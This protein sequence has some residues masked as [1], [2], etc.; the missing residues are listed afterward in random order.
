MGGTQENLYKGYMSDGISM[1][2][3]GTLFINLNAVV[4]TIQ[5]GLL[6]LSITDVGRE[7]WEHCYPLSKIICPTQAEKQK[8][9]AEQERGR[10]YLSH[11]ETNNNNNKKSSMWPHSIQLDTNI[12]TWGNYR[13]FF[14]HQL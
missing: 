7:R 3:K 8:M 10:F 2:G 4:P 12:C 1:L 6:S 14:G 11:F 5:V 13:T 9:A